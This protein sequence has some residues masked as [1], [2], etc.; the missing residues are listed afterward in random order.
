MRVSKGKGKGSECIA[1]NGTL[2][3]SYGVSPVL[4]VSVS[5]IEME[6]NLLLCLNSSL[7]SQW[8][9]QDLV[10]GGAKNKEKII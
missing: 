1:V 6:N 9:R 2:S 3:H 4:Y 7:K 10:R 8:R 5:E